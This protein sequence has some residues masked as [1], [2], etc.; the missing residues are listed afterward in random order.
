MNKSIKMVGMACMLGA[1]AFMGSSCKKNETGASDFKANMPVVKVVSID[2]D[3]RAYID[4]FDGN[5]MKWSDK[6]EVMVYN[7]NNADYTASEAYV[8]TLSRGAGTTEGYF[9]GTAFGP[10]QDDY[11]CFYPA[12]KVKNHPLEYGNS[13]I[14]DVPASQNYTANSMDPTSLVMAC[15]GDNIVTGRFNMEH[16]FGF[17]N[18]RIKGTGTVKSIV[19][20]DKAFNLNGNIRADIPGI[21]S[22]TLS[23]LIDDCADYTVPFEDYMLALTT[24]LQGV[25]Y[26][27]D[28]GD[29]TMTLDCG[30]G[31]SLSNNWTNFIITLRPGALSKGFN[32]R[33][34]FAD[35][36]HRDITKFDPDSIDFCVA[37]NPMYPRGFCVKPGYLTNYAISL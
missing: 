20:T 29:K 8:Y 24:Y 9:N 16:I 11:Y 35:G 36:T 5:K 2:D 17:I 18:L 6:D 32:V 13:Q 27:S 10:K 31:V 22:T 15:K 34:N 12:S 4:Y 7:I 25:N 33:I 3:S 30:S 19:V 21:N 28:L 23:D 1:F 37:G 26:S 14:F